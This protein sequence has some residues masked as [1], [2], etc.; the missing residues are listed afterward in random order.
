M[1][2]STNAMSFHRIEKFNRVD[3]SHALNTLPGITLANVG[4]RNESVVYVRG[5]DLRQVPVFMDGIPVYV[6]YDGYVDMGRFTTFDLA[7]IN[8]SKGF[9]SILYGANTMGGAINLVSRKPAEKFELNGRV[10][11]FSGN[12][13]NWNLNAGSR[14]GKFYFQAGVSQLKQDY[15]P[16]SS[17]FRGKKFENGDERENSY[18]DDRKI[19]LKIGFTP[20]SIDE[21]VI[22]F[23]AQM[24][25][26]GN[27][28]YIGT[29]TNIQTR[30]WQWP[31]WNKESLFFMANKQVSKTSR[32]KARLFYDTFV[33]ELV[34]YD[35]TTYTTISKGY[36]FRSFY[37]DYTI[38]GNAEYE[39]RWI[40]KN[41]TKVNVQLKHDVH[42]ENNQGEPQRNFTDNTLS[43]GL[44]NT[45]QI[46]PAF[47]I[48]PGLS[49]NMRK[50]A[51]A[52]DY[53]A[54]T[55]EITDFPSN[56]NN[57]VN[58]QLGLFWDINSNNSLRGTISRKTRF[59]TIKDRY[60][61]RMGQAIPNPDLEAEVALSY[62]LSYT[63]KLFDRVSIQASAF[64]NEISDIIQRVDNVQPNRFQL[65]N[66]GDALFYGAELAVNYQ[67]MK[68]STIGANYSYIQRNNQT[69]PD[70]LFTNVPDH[71]L[72]GF[73][74]FSIVDRINLLASAEYNSKRYS[75]SYGTKADGYTLFNAKASVKVI[76][77]MC[78]EGGINN[79][80]DKNYSL[81]EGFSEAGR[82][83]FVNIVFS[84]QGK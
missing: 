25:E 29:D 21:Y 13:F 48:V 57:A 2:D 65:Q 40:P 18:R 45:Y 23:T 80:F 49:Y 10:G 70:I 46:T 19:S 7:E 28:P 67:V 68:N 79:I 34:S 44:E 59:A 76:K 37:D 53:T 3:V 72:F 47:A 50:S 35:D 17:D 74:D 77:Y 33:N 22:G 75:T 83:F 51:K 61:Y 55:Q 20:N 42:R 58:A 24:G 54:S 14:F 39:M 16:L 64:R 71:K 27:P 4:A 38:G 84:T 69:N 56:E 31:K 60:S 1:K 5:F 66:A 36:A 52:Q 11:M 62:D 26:K 41:V 8:V 32:L 6:P 78:I 12:G 82:N 63:T 43:I 15:F 9:S 73:A 30:F 81:V